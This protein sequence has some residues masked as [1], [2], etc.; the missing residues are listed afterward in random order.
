MI[1]E[2]YHIYEEFHQINFITNHTYSIIIL[3][4]VSLL[5]TFFS[6]TKLKTNNFLLIKE[7]TTSR[8]LH[9]YLGSKQQVNE[10]YIM[11]IPEVLS[12]MNERKPI[13]SQW[14]MNFLGVGITTYVSQ[15][16]Q[17][18]TQWLATKYLLVE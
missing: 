2:V 18:V 5:Y 7:V 16:L 4:D 3:L 6:R 14:S 11:H 10:I 13:L 1:P 17:C 15:F 9:S 8:N 12:S